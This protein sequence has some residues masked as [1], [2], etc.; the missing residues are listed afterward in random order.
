M[1]DEQSEDIEE[2]LDPDLDSDLSSTTS[3]RDEKPLPGPFSL[4]QLVGGI[5]LLT[6]AAVTP[7]LWIAYQSGN[8]PQMASLGGLMILIIIAG[9]AASRIAARRV[10]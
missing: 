7:F 1:P 6:A 10:D 4:T 9:A 5:H 8:I 2:Y 3:G